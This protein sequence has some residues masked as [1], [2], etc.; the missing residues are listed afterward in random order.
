M[1]RKLSD[2][3]LL[4]IFTNQPCK[5]HNHLAE[6]TSFC[7]LCK[8]DPIK[9]VKYL[10]CKCLLFNHTYRCVIIK[11]LLKIQILWDVTLCPLVIS[12]VAKTLHDPSKCH[13]LHTSRR[14]V[15]SQQYRYAALNSR[16]TNCFWVQNS[17]NIL[18]SPNQFNFLVVFSFTH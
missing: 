12:D 2:F 18:T 6:S 13:K 11:P 1:P 8:K 9:D 17:G 16:M 7:G 14:S 10:K 4:V 5:G 15:T 3:V